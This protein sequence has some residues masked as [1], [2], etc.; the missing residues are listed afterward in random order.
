[1]LLRYCQICPP[2]YGLV[3]FVGFKSGGAP[4]TGVYNHP[5]K[6]FPQI[7]LG[8]KSWLSVVYITVASPS[9]LLLL[10]QVVRTAR[11]LADAIA[12]NS[13]LA[14]IAIMAIT[15]SNSMRVNAREC[16]R[17]IR[18]VVVRLV[19]FITVLSTRL[20]GL[21]SKGEIKNAE[22]RSMSAFANRYC[23]EKKVDEFRIGAMIS[24]LCFV[25]PGFWHSLPKV[26]CQHEIS[27]SLIMSKQRPSKESA[28]SKPP[29]I[30]SASYWRGRIFKNSYTR[31]GNRIEIKNWCFKL[32]RGGVRRT[33][34][35]QSLDQD[36]AALEAQ[37]IYRLIL[38]QGW[39]AVSSAAIPRQIAVSLSKRDAAYWRLRLVRRRNPAPPYNVASPEFSIRIEHEGRAHYFPLQTSSL[40]EAAEKAAKIYLTVSNEGWESVGSKFARELTV[41]LHWSENPLA[42]TYAT[43]Q[44]IPV[45]ADT[46]RPPILAL[47]RGGISVMLFES[48]AGV[49]LALEKCINTS[50]GFVCGGSFASLDEGLQMI[51]KRTP[52][53][54]LINRSLR[55]S[56]DDVWTNW[57]RRSP[58]L[59]MHFF[60]IYEDSDQ[61]F[62]ATPGGSSGYLLKRTPPDRLLDPIAEAV[63]EKKFIAE[64]FKFSI[65]HYFQ[66][67]IDRISNNNVTREMERLTQREHEI[68][69]LLSR[70]CVDKEIAGSLGISGWTVHGHLKKIFEKLGVHTRTEAAIKYLH[71]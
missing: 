62:R 46:K 16:A 10:R 27:L 24:L 58:N 28:K 69:T 15:T 21:A 66:T 9:C 67:V 40:A 48:D 19:F 42:W 71:K 65:Q 6:A 2:S 33:L 17:V 50:P 13:I 35:L 3:T 18:K 53:L 41:A 60:G 57:Q 63:L 26:D 8:M 37:G 59:P 30:D 4:F 36:E 44:S 1:M 31:G 54:L 61:V 14:R 7:G 29:S 45:Q 5:G 39:D 23:P 64:K 56:T 70:G 22:T 12:G 68:L 32:Q 47:K 34:S 49:R 55:P 38:A 52:G 25:I 11:A 43:I 51:R 20:I